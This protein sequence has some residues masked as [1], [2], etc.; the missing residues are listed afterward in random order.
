MTTALSQTE[1]PYHHLQLDSNTTPTQIEVVVNK[2]PQKE[3]RH[4]SDAFEVLTFHFV[5]LKCVF[6]QNEFLVWFCQLNDLD[7]VLG[8]FVAVVIGFFTVICL[9]DF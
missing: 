3:K 1:L 4:L 2:K 5:L 9:D 8:I 6:C 7:M